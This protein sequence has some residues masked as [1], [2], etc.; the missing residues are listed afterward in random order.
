MLRITTISNV[1]YFGKICIKGLLDKQYLYILTTKIF[2][3]PEFFT[4]IV[5]NL[6]LFSLEFYLA[7]EWDVKPTVWPVVFLRFPI[8]FLQIYFI[9]GIF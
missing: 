6:S 8:M 7:I 2:K 4:P 1:K 5:S 3:L 9:L